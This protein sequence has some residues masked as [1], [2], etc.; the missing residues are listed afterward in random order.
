MGVI[1][2]K[3]VPHHHFQLHSTNNLQAVAVEYLPHLP[4][5]TT[6]LYPNLSLRFPLPEFPDLFDTTEAIIAAGDVNANRSARH[7]RMESRRW[8]QLRQISTTNN[9]EVHPPHE[10]LDG[11]TDRI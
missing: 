8:N 5:L 6:P 7:G 9:V 11:R 2:R 10:P 1:I 3:E 4:L